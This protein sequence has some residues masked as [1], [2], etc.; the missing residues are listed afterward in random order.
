MAVGIGRVAV[1]G[2][3][4]NSKTSSV[5]LRNVLY[6]PDLGSVNLFSWPA[7]CNLGFVK[8]GMGSDIFMRK[9][10]N[11]DDLLWARMDC[12]EFVIQ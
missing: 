11:G 3:L 7:I 8:V 12:H 4:P 1:Q 5:I 9:E 6:V 10:L 2:K